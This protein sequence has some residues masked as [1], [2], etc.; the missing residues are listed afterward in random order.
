[1]TSMIYTNYVINAERKRENWN[2]YTMQTRTCIIRRKH[3]TLIVV[4]QIK[5][6]HTTHS[7]LDHM[8]VMFKLNQQR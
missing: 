5:K 2:W 4:S 3:L 7:V 1:M 6:I 8:C